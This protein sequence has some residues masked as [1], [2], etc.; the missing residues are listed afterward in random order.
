MVTEIRE[1]VIPV[2]GNGNGV[3]VS[4][5]HALP[6]LENGWPPRPFQIV[7]LQKVIEFWAR[8]LLQVRDRIARYAQELTFAIERNRGQEFLDSTEKAHAREVS[9]LVKVV[10]EPFGMPLTMRR[11]YSLQS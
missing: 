9:D 6:S 7:S 2:V 8:T 1:A 10:C 5:S 4:L 11:V 3:S